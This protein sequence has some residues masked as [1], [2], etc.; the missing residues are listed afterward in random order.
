ML[1]LPQ[2]HSPQTRRRAFHDPLAA[3]VTA[4]SECNQLV[5]AKARSLPPRRFDFSRRW[6]TRPALA[7][8]AALLER[9]TAAAS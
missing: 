5:E 7:E 6:N 3:L 9:T 2:T 4:A 1:D 8:T